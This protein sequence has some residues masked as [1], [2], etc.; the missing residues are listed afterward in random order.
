MSASETT[1]RVD[2]PKSKSEGSLNLVAESDTPP[3]SN[4]DYLNAEDAS[5]SSPPTTPG[6][7]LLSRTVSHNSMSEAD[8][9]S[10]PPLDRLTMLDILENLALPQ[11]LERLQHAFSLQTEKVRKH[12]QQLKSSGI[13]A[14]EKVVEEWRRRL[15][16]A[17]EQLDKYKRR[18]RGNVDRINKRWKDAKT[19]TATEKMSF[20]AG[21]L[22][23]FLS[24]Y[25]IGAYPQYF[26]YWYTVQLCYFMPIRWY[27]YHKIGYHYFLAD[28]CYFVNLLMVL[29][30]W[31]FPGSKRLFISTFCLALGNNAI[32]IAMWRNSLVFHSMDKVASLFIH[33]MPCATLHCIVHLISPELQKQK[34]PAIYSI[35]YSP[36]GSPE[37]YSL[38]SMIVWSTVPYAV[39]QLGYHFLITVRRR[40][41]IAAG[42]PTSFTWL[43][44]SY[45]KTVLGRA[46]LSLPNALQ[47]P[48][49]MVI[50]YLY[51]LLT[52]LPCPIWF[53]YR[54]ASASFLMAVFTWA[55]YNGATFYI[56]VFGKRMEKEL[57]ALRKEVSKWQNTPEAGRPTTLESSSVSS[58]DKQDSTTGGAHADHA[59]NQSVDKIPLLDQ[60]EDKT[61]TT[62][63]SATE[64]VSQDTN[65][66]RQ[67]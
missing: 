14:K 40:E 65:T 26:H 35:K 17:E 34:F 60:S 16:T 48:A 57:D 64:N 49:F 44:K 5:S 51:A 27:K 61:A 1:P 42:R 67:R 55:T 38:G 6:D 31:F 54:W 30:V 23:I 50:Q 53:W 25:F 58:T 33:I 11:R 62:S 8:D 21:V 20:I 59:R 24:G 66:A 15:P 39:W 47:E 4:T 3:P 37:H 7:A 43:R 13:S 2:I 32:A 56:D 36:P 12:Q 63:S 45:S 22:N 41:K 18:M 28:L 10:F 46:V 29:T 9:E 19:V 52:M